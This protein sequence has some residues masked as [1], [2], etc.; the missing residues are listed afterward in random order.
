MPSA[1][2]SGTPDDHVSLLDNSLLHDAPCTFKPGQSTEERV[3]P[4]TALSTDDC[5]HRESRAREAHTFEYLS[6]VHLVSDHFGVD[7][8]PLRAPYASSPHS[9]GSFHK[10][11]PCFSFVSLPSMAPSSQYSSNSFILSNPGLATFCP[12]LAPHC[13]WV[14]TTP[15][16]MQNHQ[17]HD[18]PRTLYQE[19]V[20][21]G[22]AIVDHLR[23]ASWGSSQWLPR[24]FYAPGTGLGLE[25]KSKKF[26]VPSSS[27]L[28]LSSWILKRSREIIMQSPGAVVVVMTAC[29]RRAIRGEDCADAGT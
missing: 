17:G 28:L 29:D 21:E 23:Q 13:L 22:P 9:W 16:P 18:S 10:W 8:S 27:G 14:L 24:L 20:S 15:A 4:I 26:K 3:S 5:L 12:V 6:C 11:Y 7:A 19:G 25:N 1:Q 2:V